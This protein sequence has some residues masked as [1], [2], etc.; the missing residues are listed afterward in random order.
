MDATASARAGSQGGDASVSGN[1]ARNDTAPKASSHGPCGAR[2]PAVGN[3]VEMCADGEVVWSWR[4]KSGAKLGGCVSRQPA[5][6]PDIRQVTGAI[7][8]VSPGRARRKPLKPSAQGRPS[9]GFTCDPPVRMSLHTGCGCRQAPGLPCALTCGKGSSQ[10]KLGHVAPRERE[11]ASARLSPS[12]APGR[13]YVASSGINPVYAEKIRSSTGPFTFPAR[14]DFAAPGD[15][16]NHRSRFDEN[17]NDY[18]QA[19]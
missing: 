8:L 16:A 5:R 9:V 12:S 19:F 4:P 18:R 7:E 3:P 17:Y 1:G 13:I 2:T 6:A 14:I 15:C 10:L 11:P